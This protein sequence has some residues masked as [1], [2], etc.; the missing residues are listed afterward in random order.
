[1][2]EIYLLID[3]NILNVTGEGTPVFM[4]ATLYF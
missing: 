3:M 2:F 4:T 1:M